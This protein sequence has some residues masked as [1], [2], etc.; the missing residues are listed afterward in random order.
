M[1]RAAVYRYYPDKP[2]LVDAVLIHNGHLVREELTRRL[3]DAGSFA[4]KCVVAAQFGQRMPRDGLLLSLG[5][6][7]PETLALLLTTGA[8]PFLDRATGSGWRT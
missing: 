4:D 6:T 7:E 8:A 3:D 2:S 1:S 5:E